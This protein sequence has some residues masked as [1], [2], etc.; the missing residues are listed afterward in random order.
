[1]LADG[2]NFLMR[3]SFQ[4]LDHVYLA[5]FEQV[6]IHWRVNKSKRINLGVLLSLFRNDVS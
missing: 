1:M 4:M 2:S 5:D 6:F 3:M